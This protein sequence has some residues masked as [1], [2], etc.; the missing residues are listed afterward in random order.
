MAYDLI[1]IGG[2]II[3]TGI[4]REAALRGL[5]VALFE[6]DDFGSGTTSRS[7]RIIHGGLRYLERLELDLVSEALHERKRLLANAPHLVKPLP[8]LFPVYRDR[9]HPLAVLWA[10][11]GLYDLLNIRR[12][13]PHHRMLTADQAIRVEP[14]LH[15]RGLKA[16]FIY[17]DAQCQFP[18]RVC[19]ENVIDAAAHG[20]RI[21]NHCP[22]VGLIREDGR[23]TGVRVRR[24]LDDEDEHVAA[25]LVINAGGPW[26]DEVQRLL[27]PE[28]P[29]M[30]RRT[31]GVHLVV[32]RFNHHALIMETQDAKRIFFAVPWGEYTLLGTTDTDYEGRNEEVASEAAD[33]EYLLHELNAVLAVDLKESDILFTTAGLRPLRREVGKHAGDVSR[34]HDF[35]DHARDGV[36][37]FLTVVGGKIT[38]FRNIAHEA[39]DLAERKLGVRHVPSPTIHRPFPGAQAHDW[40]KFQAAF[41][42]E[43]RD[44]GIPAVVAAHW[45][46]TYGTRSRRLLELCQMH[47]RLRE[48]VS[49]GEP[50]L[51]A[52]VAFAV[53]EEFCG[54]LSDFMLRRSMLGLRAGQG[55]AAIERVLEELAA[56]LGWEADRVREER[57]AYVAQLARMGT[58]GPRVP[59]EGI[60]GTTAA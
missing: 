20:A 48:A 52:E 37:G 51:L 50:V 11:I 56:R 5:K 53:D 2:G 25:R 21:E 14:A 27:E 60:R 28:A 58:A 40:D 31:K 42:A 54:S 32:P 15:P 59:S 43:A 7:T 9:G 13:M 17:Y 29:S 45:L 38:T 18:E 46:S 12:G 8:F 34:K 44:A 47:V 19:V 49:P 3:G 55:R 1:V 16:G 22:V 36:E 30:L 26:L 24:P 41:S 23:V 6:K 33:V 39:V 4:A 35:L 10:G 57:D